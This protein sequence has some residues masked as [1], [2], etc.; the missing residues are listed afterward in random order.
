M[1]PKIKKFIRRNKKQIKIGV[2]VLLALIILIILYKS[3]FYSSS[4]SAIYGVR[5]R[6]IKDNLFTKEEKND[7]KEKA[8]EIEGV[9]DVRVEV[10]GR[11]IKVFATFDENVSTDDMKN[12]FNEM[13]TFVSEKITGY[14]D[15]EFYSTQIK[16]GKTVYPVTGY[17]HKNKPEISFDVL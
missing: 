9:S 11:L 15:I 13:L 1:L 2:L 6:N 5:L 4:Q 14:Y 7:I 12:K 17:K 8:S 3:L 10:K 16:E